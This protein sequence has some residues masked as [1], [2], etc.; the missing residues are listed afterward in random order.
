L[1]WTTILLSMFVQEDSRLYTALIN[2]H[3]E[4]IVLSRTYVWQ[5]ATLNLAIHFH[6]LR[7]TSGLLDP[8][9]WVLSSHLIDQFTR[10]KAISPDP[11]RAPGR[12]SAPRPPLPS[13]DS[14]YSYVCHNFNNGKCT[15]NPCRFKHECS[16]AGCGRKDHGAS[17]HG[18]AKL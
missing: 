18:E 17:K 14:K 16:I 4:I 13:S 7:N 5:G 2:F 11:I 1:I 12:S 3:L 15:F 8:D 10:G 9:Q 6:N